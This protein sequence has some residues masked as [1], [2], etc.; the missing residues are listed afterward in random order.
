MIAHVH[1]NA[2]DGLLSMS[3]CLD[4]G[5]GAVLILDHLSPISA[6]RAPPQ[7]PVRGG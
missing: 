4:L 5:E 6:I 2:S 3:E 1:T 7:S